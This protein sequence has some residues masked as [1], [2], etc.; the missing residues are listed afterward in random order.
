MRTN[1]HHLSYFV[2]VFI[3]ILGFGPKNKAFAQ[4]FPK[5]YSG[6]SQVFQDN[7]L[8][9]EEVK[10][11]LDSLRTLRPNKDSL[12]WLAPIMLRR[13]SE[14]NDSLLLANVYS[15]FSVLFGNIYRDLNKSIEYNEKAL[16]LFRKLPNMSR[17]YLQAISLQMLM[18]YD[19]QELDKAMEYALE[20]QQLAERQEETLAKLYGY[21]QLCTFYIKVPDFERAYEFCRIGIKL[22]KKEERIDFLPVFYE[23]MAIIKSVKEKNQDS[24]IYYRKK[25]ISLPN[26]QE[27]EL[28]VSYRNLAMDYRDLGIMDSAELYFNKSIKISKKYPW[29]IVTNSTFIEYAAF[30]LKDKKPEAASHIL[31]SLIENSL[32]GPTELASL[33]RVKLIASLDLDDQG[34]FHISLFKRDSILMDKYDQEKT[35][36]REEMI[37][38]YEL[39][40]KEAENLRLE[41][42]NDLYRWYIILAV[43]L[44]SSLIAVGL[45]LR[46]KAKKKVEL[47][48]LEAEKEAK[49]LKFVKEKFEMQRQ[50]LREII[51]QQ[52]LEQNRN[53]ELMEMVEELSSSAENK[54]VENKAKIIQRKLKSY[55]S[56][57]GVEKL[58]VE[59]RLVYPE[60]YSFLENHP[61]KSNKIELTYCLMVVMGYSQEDVARALQRSEKAIKSLRYRIRKKMELSEDQSLKEYLT[62][63]Q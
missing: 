51:N 2:L 46:D 40:E 24:A 11:Y 13:V 30:L 12:N 53:L 38:K 39:M 60:L 22:N 55:S 61:S 18:S 58:R 5:N 33:Y 3:F 14:M 41:K 6:V 56:K 36:A 25:G 54:I 52:M 20:L 9:T 57:D 1:Q 45:L 44:V 19:N 17:K 15:K 43:I 16:N 49:R 27:Y 50:R 32:L 63:R 7:K 35:L 47:L 28:P 34:G 4:T 10:V 29:P 31:D 59:A 48:K 23:T 26:I 62:S 8:A 42:R 21:R 37:A